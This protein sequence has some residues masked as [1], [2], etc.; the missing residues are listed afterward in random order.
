MVTL[1][2]PRAWSAAVQAVREGLASEQ[3]AWWTGKATPEPAQERAASDRLT[4]AVNGD[5]WRQ[6]S[7]ALRRIGLWAEVPLLDFA[8]RPP[9]DVD[10]A[11]PDPHRV[12]EGRQT[13]PPRSDR[14]IRIPCGGERA[15]SE[16]ETHH[17]P[18]Q[19]TR[20]K[21]TMPAVQL[22]SQSCWSQ[23]KLFAT[24]GAMVP[25][26][27]PALRP[28]GIVVRPIYRPSLAIRQGRASPRGWRDLSLTGDARPGGTSLASGG[29]GVY[30]GAARVLQGGER[31]WE[32]A[33]GQL[34]PGPR[35][36][37]GGPVRADGGPPLQDWACQPQQ[38]VP[39]GPPRRAGSVPVP[40]HG[41]P[42][43]E[44]RPLPGGGE[45]DD[46]A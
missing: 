2:R 24:G 40:C 13:P 17:Q 41:N 6:W 7:T 33:G 37:G 16:E 18:R 4:A 11:G 29:A 39:A 31:G 34:C 3:D 12:E 30:P 45:L 44:G 38:R 20:G 25:R 42:L 14:R 46:R 27:P 19:V 28:C 9:T 22:L 10:L 35:R 5:Q 36:C 15:H 8:T 32:V 21:P 26:S 43:Q 1:L 23:T